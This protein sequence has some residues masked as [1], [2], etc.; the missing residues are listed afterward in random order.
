MEEVYRGLP[1][2][3]RGQWEV[4]VAARRMQCCYWPGPRHTVLR[5]SW[6]VG[7][8]SYGYTASLNET[9]ANTERGSGEWLPLRENIADQLEET[10]KGGVWNPKFQHLAPQPQGITA[11]RIELMTSGS[12]GLCA[13]FAGPDEAYLCTDDGLGWLRKLSGAP[14]ARLRRG[15]AAPATAAALAAEADVKVEEL[16]QAAAT[17][18]VAGLVLFVHGIG[19]SESAFQLEYEAPV[20]Y[21]CT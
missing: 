2:V 16:D 1:T 9:V 5:G 21:L 8:C 14:V 15:Y 20:L 12:K 17:T 13:L 3:K 4:D 6:F 10:Y 19:V 11:A 18:P 7:A